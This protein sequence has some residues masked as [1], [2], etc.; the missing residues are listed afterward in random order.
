MQD[1]GGD[2]LKSIF[3]FEQSWFKVRINKFVVLWCHG[4]RKDIFTS[5]SH[6][7]AVRG[8]MN[9]LA[10]LLAE[11]GGSMVDGQQQNTAEQCQCCEHVLV[12]D[13]C[14]GHNTT[15]KL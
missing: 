1:C 8:E 14:S 2:K 13:H 9:R 12:T 4:W 3:R 7:S 10:V 5:L 11:L 6:L 15:L